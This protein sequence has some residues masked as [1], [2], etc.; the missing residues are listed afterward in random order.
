MSSPRR[1][2]AAEIVAFRAKSHDFRSSKYVNSTY[3][4]RPEAGGRPV[5]SVS[6]ALPGSVQLWRN[7]WDSNPLSPPSDKLFPKI[8]MYATLSS[9]VDRER[10]P[11]READENL[12]LRHY[13]RHMAHLAAGAD[14]HL[15]VEMETKLGVCENLAPLRR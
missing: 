6:A 14:L 5:I 15:A 7:P 2:K 9:K 4:P 8:R 11:M 12:I 13:P 1:L 3:R 10:A